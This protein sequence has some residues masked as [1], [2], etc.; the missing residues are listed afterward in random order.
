MKCKKITDAG[1]LA[2]SFASAV[3]KLC[4]DGDGLIAQYGEES[5]YSVFLSL[6]PQVSYAIIHICC[7][8][9]KKN[10]IATMSRVISLNYTDG[11]VLWIM[12][13]MSS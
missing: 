13:G 8:C 4:P 6:F 9:P 7:K 1:Q 12:S 3:T 2:V 5:L 11:N 10:K